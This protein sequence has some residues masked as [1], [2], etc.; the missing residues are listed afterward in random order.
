MDTLMTPKTP[1]APPE[2]GHAAA[3]PHIHTPAFKN[4]FGDWQGAPHA[5]SKVVHPETGEPLRMFHGTP[6]AGFN[7]FDPSFHGATTDIGYYGPGHYFTSDPREAT[8]YSQR[9]GGNAAGIYPAYLSLK[10]PFHIDFRTHESA[11]DTRRRAREAGV[12]LNWSGFAKDPEAFR[13]ALEEKGHDGVTAWRSDRDNMEAVAFHPHQIKSV[14][15]QGSFDPSSHDIRYARDI[16]DRLARLD[17]F[18]AYAAVAPPPMPRPIYPDVPRKGPTDP[19][20]AGAFA[21]EGEGFIHPGLAKPKLGGMPQPTGLATHRPPGQALGSLLPSP[22]MERG[23]PGQGQPP[24]QEQSPQPPQPQQ[25]PTLDDLLAGGHAYHALTGGFPWHEATTGHHARMLDH[26]RQLHPAEFWDLVHRLH[27]HGLQQQALQGQQ[28]EGDPRATQPLGYA[29]D[30]EPVAYAATDLVDTSGPGMSPVASLSPARPAQAHL[31]PM[32]ASMGLVRTAM[33]LQPRG[34]VHPVTEAN[35]HLAHVVE[36]PVPE[37]LHGLPQGAEKTPEGHSVVFGPTGMDVAGVLQSHGVEGKARPFGRDDHLPA[38]MRAQMGDTPEERAAHEERGP[39]L[40]DRQGNPT[41][42]SGA[43]SEPGPALGGAGPRPAPASLPSPHAGA[44]TPP[45]HAPATPVLPTPV[46]P[47]HAPPAAAAPPPADPFPE[48][49]RFHQLLKGARKVG[50]TETGWN[51]TRSFEHG[52]RKFFAKLPTNLHEAGNEVAASKIQELLG[53]PDA[54]RVRAMPG[55]KGERYVVSPQLPGEGL[56]TIAER[57]DR[58]PVGK[59]GELSSVAEAAR[60]VRAARPGHLAAKGFAHWLLNTADR[61]AGNNLYHEGGVNPIDHGVSFYPLDYPETANWGGRDAL[62]HGLKPEE[63]AALPLDRKLVERTLTHRD[64]ILDTLRQ[65]VLPHRSE[66]GNYSREKVLQHYDAKFRKLENLLAKD[67][68]L[69]LGDLG[70]DG[71][72]SLPTLPKH[73][74]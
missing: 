18:T 38:S 70:I 47:T 3:T 22:Q 14:H 10:N 65:D 31:A 39:Q 60:M 68:P 9:R 53:I 55:P 37:E 44:F 19:L 29:R 63:V 34:P 30:G 59:G 27:Q 17:A 21:P 54:Q 71:R 58:T 20:N 74:S 43:F 66:R 12:E 23:A 51:E 1:G 46:L 33:K 48:G 57:I 6:R 13:R 35:R 28:G 45:L 4:W 16:P 11:G 2:G 73:T 7:E 62:F 25:P 32:R 42:Y 24:P 67:G 52:G 64:P 41:A 49:K 50:D 8:D 72:V 5:A 36:G 69:T 15:N 26:L 40:Y 56:P 61:H